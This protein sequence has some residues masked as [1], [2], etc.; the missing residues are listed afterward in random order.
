MKRLLL[1]V[2]SLFLLGIMGLFATQN[3][4]S[5][6]IKIYENISI[7]LSLWILI[8]ISFVSGW[9]LTEIWQ[10]FLHPNR[11][12]QSFFGKFSRY[13]EEKTKQLTQDFEEASLLRDSKMLI[14]NYKKLDSKQIPLSI[15]VKYIW[16]LRYN[17]SKEELLM[18]FAE[19]RA[20]YQGD[21]EVLLPYLKLVCEVS[22]WNVAERLCQEILLKNP[23]HPDAMEGLRK[24]YIAKQDWVSCIE[25]ERE[26]L[27]KFKCSLFTEN[28][29]I[30]HEDHIQKA[31]IQDPNCLKNWS[32]G[33][34]P[35]TRN[36]INLK[37]L[38][39]LCQSNQ[40]K[41]KGLYLEA[42][43]VVKKS[44]KKTSFPELLE[45]LEN[46]YFVSGRDE[47]ILDIV[48]DI[49]SSQNTSILASI[50]FAKLLYKNDK[51]DQA[52]KIL[53]EIKLEKIM[54]NYENKNIGEKFE[55]KEINEKWQNLF[56]ALLFFIAIRQDSLEVAIKEAKLL[57]REAKFF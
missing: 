37:K 38:E 9:A 24:C 55:D 19:L 2:V 4:H 31:L 15:H 54:L 48:G 11:F 39:V 36:K 45:E 5:V 18:K 25:Q 47:Q 27:E 32:F 49:H 56:H 6:S 29:V 30:E 57:L 14:K 43:K 44:F 46:L 12:V 35:K 28:L 8:V 20:K 10:F 7:Q 51:L 34:F 17:S 26:L 53:N 33:Y 21:L 41:K 3:N 23:A 22:E 40:L 16:Q 13:K 50:L 42:G 1:I 52:K